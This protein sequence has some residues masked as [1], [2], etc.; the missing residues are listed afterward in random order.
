MSET[1]SASHA[2]GKMGEGLGQVVTAPMASLIELMTFG[3]PI[4]RLKQQTRQG[5]SDI[6]WGPFRVAGHLGKGAVKGV[7]RLAW[8]GITNAPILPFTKLE[9]KDFVHA[10]TQNSLQSFRGLLDT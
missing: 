9:A 1:A 5:I 10:K 4:D 3:S 2:V 6:L 8:N 7:G